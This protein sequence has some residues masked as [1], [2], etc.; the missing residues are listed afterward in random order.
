MAKLMYNYGTHHILVECHQYDFY[1]VIDELSKEFEITKKDSEHGNTVMY[2]ITNYYD[3]LE[4]IG[5]IDLNF[6]SYTRRP[7]SKI[8]LRLWIRKRMHSRNR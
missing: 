6:E 2:Y 3:E 1:D 5:S 7:A 8:P 4:Y